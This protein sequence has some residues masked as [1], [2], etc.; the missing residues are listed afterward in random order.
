MNQTETFLLTTEE[1]LITNIWESHQI[2]I[3]DLHHSTERSGFGLTLTEGND[4]AVAVAGHNEWKFKI[5]K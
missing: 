2:S 5:E 3:P 4:A 1:N